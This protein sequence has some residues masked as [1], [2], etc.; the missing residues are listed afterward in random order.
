MKK[1]IRFG[2][3]FVLP[4]IVLGIALA[5][6]TPLKADA[7]IWTDKGDYGP[8]ETVHIFGTGFLTETTINISVTRPDGFVD[9]LT[10]LSLIDGSFTATYPPYGLL[11]EGTY[12][13]EATDGENS[14]TTTFT[15]APAVFSITITTV[16]S[17]ATPT[18]GLA[19]NASCMNFPGQISQYQ[20]QI[21]WGDGTVDVNSNVN[22]TVSGKNFSGTWASDP[23]H[24]YTAGGTYTITVK[25][26]HSQPPGNEAGD[27][28]V[29]TTIYITPQTAAITVTTSPSGLSIVV[30]A[31][32]YTAPQTFSWNIDSTHSIGTTSPQAGMAGV[33][34]V[35]NNWSDA[36]N[37]THDI[38]TPGTPTTYTA[39]FQTQ[40]K[41][42]YAA[43]VPVTVPADEWVL[44]GG[45]AVGVFPTPVISGGTKYVYQS[46]D[47]PGTITA[48]TTITATYQTQYYL[49]VNSPLSTPGGAG[50]YNA[51]ATAYAT[52]TDSIVTSGDT[53]YVFAGWTGE[54]SGTKKTSDPITMSGPKTATASWTTQFYLTVNTDG[55]GTG[56]V[57]KLPDQTYYNYGTY[58]KLTAIPG[59]N[60]HFAGWS[61][62][63]TGT[64]NPDSVLMDGAKTV[65]ATFTLDTFLLT[66]SITGN[67]TGT[68]TKNPNQT[69]YS[70][71][72]WAH[73]TANAGTGSRF[74]S[75]SG[76]LT[77]SHNP[78]SVLMNAAK[79][80]T[81]T[82]TLN[83]FLLTVG[84]AGN[85]T[86]TATKNPNQPYY[87]YGTWVRLTAT[88]GAHSYFAR[89]SGNLTG[90]NSPDSVLMNADKN[91][92]ATFTLDTFLLTVSITGSGTGTVVKNPNQTYYSYG[93]RVRLTATPGVESR[94]DGWSGNLTGS[95]SPDSVL[96]NAAKSVT[97]TFPLDTFLLTVYTMGNGTVTKNP[98]Q[99]YYNGGTWVRLTA[100]TAPGSHFMG[101]SDS[102]TGRH[103]PDSVLMGS[104][105][106]IVTAS[107]ATAGHRDVGVA[108]IVK[109]GDTVVVRNAFNPVVKIINLD[110]PPA[111]EPVC[112]VN[113]YIWRYRVK[114]DSPCHISNNPLDSALVY[115]EQRVVPADSGYSYDTFPSW[116]PLY[117]DLYWLGSPTH[118]VIRATV[119]MAGD[120][121]PANDSKQKQ[122]IVKSR[123]YDLQ[124]NYAGLVRGSVA[125]PDTVTAGISYNTV[126]VVS[127]S[128]AGPRASFR[129]WFKIIKVRTNQVVYSQFLDRTLNPGTYTC[130]YYPSGYVLVEIGLYKISSYIETRP[131]VDSTPNNNSVERFIYA[132]QPNGSGPQSEVLALPQTF[133]LLQNYPNP[134]FATTSIRWQIPIESRVTI[135]IYDAT[136]RNIKTLQ[137]GNFAP[138]YYTT[139]WDCTSD[140]NQKVASG[141]YFYEMKTNN[142]TTR[143]KMVI[144]N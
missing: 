77:G 82:F 51:G 131:G 43:N 83:N 2:N 94:F 38:T 71:G 125:A 127:N 124:M 16:D 104:G 102:L 56:S 40:Y 13:V 12:T 4:L 99:V 140:N 78:D 8:E 23:N 113:V 24:T 93:T 106:Q 44:S 20:V 90:S 121:N 88:A 41:V 101:W 33:Q 137:N 69:Y 136:G 28:V 34:Y 22:F 85:G 5:M 39:N 21:N 37:Q 89:W 79:S 117:A 134:F 80:V 31:V 6:A 59:A 45:S 25:I 75:W 84:I 14:A 65:T 139:N 144:T 132:R 143:R 76:N 91:V 35:W 138:G 11:F 17:S 129:S 61:G 81:A 48:P 130:L 32:T 54:A 62:S 109:P 115:S 97:A 96:M 10:T 55:N 112:T 135:S 49:T 95:N 7:L 100:D 141:I 15:D 53:Q 36:G 52:I 118:H 29:S 27:A 46:D 108:N 70:Y 63:L 122:F 86:G 74:A 18:I 133:A 50:W 116:N 92:T 68:L 72:T 119:R 60:S 67:G 64:N 114:I 19:G 111:N 105:N 57:D 142:Y 47:R 66:V 9:N 128:P 110:F 120:L 107:F 98:D 103:N 42:T 3:L 87:N 1:Q 26:Y 30:D 126:S 123:K 73:L 58:V